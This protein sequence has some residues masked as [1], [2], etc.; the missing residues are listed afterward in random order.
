MFSSSFQL[1]LFCTLFGIQCA[2]LFCDVEGTTS[3]TA[4]HVQ[5]FL[6]PLSS[7]VL[8]IHESQ[9]ARFERAIIQP[10]DNDEAETLISKAA[11]VVGWSTLPSLPS[12]MGEVAAAYINGNI[13]VMGEGSSSTYVYNIAS[14]SWSKVSTRPHA[15]D[16]HALVKPG[17]GTFW[18]VG[19]F[20]GGSGSTVSGKAQV[21]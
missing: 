2:L 6:H 3:N 5:D 10:N 14:Q 4:A 7:D 16:H 8:E 21:F 20:N 9:D 1:R 15:G 12:S 11:A 19:G 17:D 13:Y 18:L